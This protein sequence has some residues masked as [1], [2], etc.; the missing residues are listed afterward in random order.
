MEPEKSKNFQKSI[1]Y[2]A[3]LV[4]VV[5]AGIYLYKNPNI[6]G[7]TLEVTSFKGVLVGVDGNKVTLRGTYLSNSPLPAN[8]S[9][10]RDFTFTVSDRTI[11][12]KTAITLPSYSAIQKA[13]GAT[14]GTFDPKYLPHSETTGS[15]EDLKNPDFKNNA[16][17]QVGFSVSINKIQNPVS[18]YVQYTILVPSP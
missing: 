16:V 6:F 12:N 11:F 7:K 10:S 9:G 8:L 18:S 3:I 2:L 1:F 14:H 17:V 15:I 5:G 13:T 4:I